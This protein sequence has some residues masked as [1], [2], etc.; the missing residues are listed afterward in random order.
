[1]RVA[2]R[3]RTPQRCHGDALRAMSGFDRDIVLIGQATLL[4]VRAAD[5][6]TPIF[7][8]R[9]SVAG[10]GAKRRLVR[11]SRLAPRHH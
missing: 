1:V 6:R 4:P 3:W 11:Q 5:C 2:V 10:S 9:D 8:I 7:R